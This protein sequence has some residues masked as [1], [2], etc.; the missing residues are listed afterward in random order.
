MLGLKGVRLLIC[1]MQH[2]IHRC[3]SS[4]S[5]CVQKSVV[6]FLAQPASEGARTILRFVTTPQAVRTERNRLDMSLSLLYSHLL[7]L[8]TLKDEMQTRT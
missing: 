8:P 4:S 7:K 5:I 6:L 1:D 3:S 2:M